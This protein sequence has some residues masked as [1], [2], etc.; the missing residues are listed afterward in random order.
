MPFA[1]T[2][3]CRYYHIKQRKSNRE[4]QISC[5]ITYMWNL[6]K[7]KKMIQMNL[8]KKQKQTHRLQKHQKGKV[9]EE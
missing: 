7:K 5:Y 1:A 6:K 9:D 3:G 2:D 8:L 4:R